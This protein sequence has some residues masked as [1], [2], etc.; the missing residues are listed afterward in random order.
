[1]KLRL[2]ASLMVILLCVANG[3]AQSGA[4]PAGSVPGPGAVT[5]IRKIDFANYTYPSTLCSRE[6]G[7][8]GIATS[9]R[10]QKGEFK[11]GNAYFTVEQDG[12]LYGDVSGDGQEDAVVPATCGAT[13]ANFSR[14][15][16]YVYTI[17]NGRAALIAEITDRDL[18]RDYRHYY[19]DTETY[20]GTAASGVR[21]RDGKLEID[22]LADGSHASPKYVATMAYRVSGPHPSVVAK[23]ERRD[24]SQ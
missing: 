5:D 10:V 12:I 14:S 22:V 8:Q 24:S 3:V 20:W 17:K 16:Y 1:M 19:P 18:E 2:I 23:P 6:Y 13:G 21:V 15:E 4:K 11:H 7:K 9:V